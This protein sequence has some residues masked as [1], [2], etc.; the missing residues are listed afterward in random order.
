MV[1]AR[2]GT[3]L[4]SSHSVLRVAEEV[5]SLCRKGLGGGVPVAE[6]ALQSI[7]LRQRPGAG[8]SPNPWVYGLT[9]VS[10]GCAGRESD[11]SV[12]GQLDIS[13]LAG[14]LDQELIGALRQ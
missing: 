11:H 14:L 12:M 9:A 4:P 8:M 2:Q 6:Q 5:A 13:G 10:K 1:P 7:L 3:P